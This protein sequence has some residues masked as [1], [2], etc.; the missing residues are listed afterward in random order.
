[1][2]LPENRTSISAKTTLKIGETMHPPMPLWFSPIFQPTWM[3]RVAALKEMLD[4]IPDAADITLE[5]EEGVALVRALYDE[6]SK[7][8]TEEQKAQ[9]AD[10]YARLTAAEAKIAELKASQF[11]FGILRA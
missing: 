5:D 1:M 11:F 2:A 7:E 4:A 8:L 10:S 3:K 6:L 9:L